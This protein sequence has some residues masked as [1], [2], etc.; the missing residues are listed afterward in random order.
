LLIYLYATAWFVK[1]VQHEYHNCMYVR[2]HVIKKNSMSAVVTRNHGMRSSHAQVAKYVDTEL[3][4]LSWPFS[5]SVTVNAL[6]ADPRAKRV[7]ISSVI[8]Q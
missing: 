7:L 4:S 3:L 2:I 1:M 8:V 6:K 5:L